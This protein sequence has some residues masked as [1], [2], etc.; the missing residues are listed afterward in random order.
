[1]ENTQLRDVCRQVLENYQR[2]GL[3]RF[4]AQS[5]EELPPAVLEQLAALPGRQQVPAAPAAATSQHAGLAARPQTVH[6]AASRPQ[7]RSDSTAADTSAADTSATSNVGATV[8]PPPATVA[9]PPEGLGNQPWSL[10]LL[11]VTQ[12]QQRFQSLAKEVCD[13][14]K[15]GEIVAYR[16]QTVFGDGP[17][18]PTICFLG[19]APGADEDR[20][21]KPFVGA[22]GQLL[23]K[24][25]AAMKLRREE[26][27][28]LNALK[29][30]PPQNRTPMPEE[31]DN[32]RG[33]V[34]TQLDT[35]QPQYIVCLGAVAVRSILHTHQP[36]GRLRGRFHH[37][38]GARVLVTYHPSYLLRNQSAKKLVWADM[39]MLMKELPPSE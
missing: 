27:Y 5:V 11:D 8:P 39:Q 6:P 4:A 13:C 12:R 10:P 29:C 33:F 19:E 7:S 36:I 34:E 24:I 3:R 26:V 20:Q 14:R 32:C 37:Y 21:G 18:Q 30:R 16:Q 25:I 23:T 15:C 35:L 31:I 38:R 9:L 17:L 22:A 1:M 2:C 28:I